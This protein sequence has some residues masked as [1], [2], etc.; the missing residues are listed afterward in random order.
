MAKK[1]FEKEGEKFWRYKFIKATFFFWLAKNRLQGKDLFWHF[2]LDSQTLK[3]KFFK[4]SQTLN[5]FT[6]TS[7]KIDHQEKILLRMVKKIIRTT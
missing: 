6:N 1:F 7:S 3:I 2:S 4:V 5:F